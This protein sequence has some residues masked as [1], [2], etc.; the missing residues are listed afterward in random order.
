M[1]APTNRSAIAATISLGKPRAAGKPLVRP[2]SAAVL[3]RVAAEQ[4]ASATGKRTIRELNARGKR[5]LLRVDFNVPLSDGKI[6]DDARIRAAIPTI[7]ALL[8]AGASVVLASHLG[9]PDGKVVDGLRLRP[10]AERLSALMKIQVPTT[11]DA[12]GVGTDD[13]VKRLRPGEMLLLEN[14]RFHAA[15]EKNDPAFAARLASYADVFVN[16]AF[17]AAHRAHA[18]VVGVAGILPAYIGLLIE[19][20][21][22]TLSSLLDNPKRPFAAIVGGGKVS[23]KI[24]VLEALLRK[25]DLLVLGGGIANTFLVASHRSVGKSLYEPKMVEDRKSTRLNSSHVKRSRMPSSA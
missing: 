24:A 15:E 7:Q 22:E 2:S 14:V 20:E 16:D 11:G 23:G 10:A 12:L 18:S 6:V 17:G 1:R 8:E 4:I 19:R 13:A 5:V 25:V 3:R 21:I 9:R